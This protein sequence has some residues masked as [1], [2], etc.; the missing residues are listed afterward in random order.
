[1]PLIYGEGQRAFIRLQEEIM[2]ISDDHSLFAWRSLDNHNGLLATSPAMFIRSGNI[3]PT[4][5]FD[6]FGTPLTVSNKGIHLTLPVMGI[7]HNG[8]ALAIL[9][10]KEVGEID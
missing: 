2:K 5:S 8:L 3:V 4:E 1:M 7:D 10:C 6:T 9:Y